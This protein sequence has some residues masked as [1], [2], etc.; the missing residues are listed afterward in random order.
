MTNEKDAYVTVTL[1]GK[2]ARLFDAVFALAQVT[3]RPVFMSY[4]EQP[5][6]IMQFHPDGRAQPVESVR[7]QPPTRGEPARRGR[8]E[9][10]DE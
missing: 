2:R 3:G 1:R 4:V 10:P 5:Q 7:H 8:P 9:E 6:R